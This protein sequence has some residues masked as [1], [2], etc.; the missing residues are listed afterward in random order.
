MKSL[1][2]IVEIIVCM[3]FLFM[4][5]ALFIRKMLFTQ[6]PAYQ[7][8]LVRFLFLSCIFSPIE[9]QFVNLPQK[10]IFTRVPSNI[11]RESS[12]HSIQ[13]KIHESLNEV[14]ISVSS[15]QNIEMT[16]V[17]LI[18]ATLFLAGLLYR[19]YKIVKDINKTKSL[20][21]SAQPYKKHGKITI[22]ISDQC[23][24]PF[25]IRLIKTSYIILPVSILHS[26]INTK[27]AILHEGQHH[28][29]GDCLWAYLIEFTRIIFWF[30]PAINYWHKNFQELQELAC[31]E[32]LVS[33]NRV[34]AYD[35]GSCLF[36]L[37]QV[38]SQYL[39]AHH[40]HNACTAQMVFSHKNETSLITRRICMLS[41]YK[42]ERLS[43]P[44]FG[45]ILA[46][47]ALSII[48]P[49]S[50]AY[51]TKGL[52][53]QGIKIDSID[54]SSVDPE[55]QNSAI[56]EITIAVNKSHAKSGAIVI[57]DARTG[58]IVAFAE[59]GKASES[60]SW[61]SRVFNPASTI[62]PFIAAAAIDAGVASSLTII[63]CHESYQIDGKRFRNNNSK[64]G[65]ISIADAMANSVNTCAIKL[66]QE[67]GSSKT[68]QILTRFGFD[69]NAAWDANN[70]DALNLANA[71]MGS[72][73][74]VTL[75]TL[76]N[77][78]TILANKGHFVHPNSGNVISE[79]TA[80]SV[81]HLLEKAV[82]DG[83]GK[84]AVISNVLVAGK[85]GTLSN[86]MQTEN[87]ALFA[88]YV[89][90]HFPRYVSIVV[91]ENA[92][93]NDSLSKANGGNTAAPV[94]RKVLEKSLTQ[95]K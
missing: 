44:M 15:K 24:V 43:K 33:K 10:S 45:S 23:V 13:N 67:T 89:P 81:T 3:N 86:E 79:E 65:N 90:S 4:V 36:N 47:S 62:K 8:L 59:A 38:A 40:Q 64:M 56:K 22:R 27:L 95:S 75:K 48:V 82:S 57:A 84:R 35:Y 80:N 18:L 2:P 69:M 61:R 37:T 17:Y 93:V 50:T 34:S 25:S 21:D 53:S 63:D 16:Y 58:K 39:N 11:I 6:K 14:S 68:R 46:I 32:T 5:G 66:A 52:I 29:Q 60:N 85:T 28:R 74:P 54:T 12:Y 70:S 76:T 78:F 19:T 72:S 91:I 30:N 71:A 20:I 7:L 55:I 49:L 73:I 31:D 77:A 1:I 26:S 94:F 88:G 51:A 87:L 83:T 92:Q 42:N 41:K 9:I